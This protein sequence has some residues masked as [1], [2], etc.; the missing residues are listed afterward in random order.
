MRMFCGRW[1][2]FG[3]R[4]CMQGV[5]AVGFSA[6]QAYMTDITTD[7]AGGATDNRAVSMAAYYGVSQGEA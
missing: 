5:F 2:M 6:G 7:A 3:P 4:Y 1:L